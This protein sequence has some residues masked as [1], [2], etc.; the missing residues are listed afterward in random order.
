[1]KRVTLAAGGVFLILGLAGLTASG[2]Q[3]PLIALATACGI[4]GLTYDG[5]RTGV[6]G[7]VDSRGRKEEKRRRR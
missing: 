1:M 2:I 5:W 4:L 7:D 6:S 3:R